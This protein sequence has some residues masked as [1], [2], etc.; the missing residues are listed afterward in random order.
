MKI[1]K[2]SHKEALYTQPDS[3]LSYQAK[4]VRFSY[5]LQQHVQNLLA[6]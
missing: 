5:S 4:K 6:Q 3:A 2:N 1:V